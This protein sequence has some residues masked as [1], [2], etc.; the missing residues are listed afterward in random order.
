VKHLNVEMKAR[1]SEVGHIR[2]LLRELGADFVGTDHQVDTYFHLPSGRLKLRE[3]NIERSLIFYQRDDLAEVKRSEVALYHPQ[4]DPAPLGELLHLALGTK[5]KVDKKREIYFIDNV[6]FHLDEVAG[7]GSFVEIEAIDRDG[8][9]GEAKLRDQ[10]NHYLGL[11]RIGAGDLVAGS[12]S[13]LLAQ[14]A[15][16]EPLP[17]V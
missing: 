13:D 17:T 1:C 7:L 12:Y 16:G 2:Q 15:P 11:F 5:V 3:G 9:L 10:C 8:S 14:A 4:G 6:K